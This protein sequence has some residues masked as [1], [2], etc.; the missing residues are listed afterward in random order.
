LIALGLTP[1]AEVSVLQNRGR[2]PL[3]VEAHGARIALGRRQADRV[4][5]DLGLVPSRPAAATIAAA[6][7]CEETEIAS[8]KAGLAEI[9]SEEVPVEAM[10]SA[11]GK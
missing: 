5:V 7:Q 6:T 10:N 9:A 8:D 11:A 2:G 3:I 4:T 1:G